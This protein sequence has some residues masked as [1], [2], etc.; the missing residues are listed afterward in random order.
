MEESVRLSSHVTLKIE[1]LSV[2]DEVAFVNS[3]KL[4]DGV[5]RRE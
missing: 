5:Y 2:N 4:L 1:L 3:G